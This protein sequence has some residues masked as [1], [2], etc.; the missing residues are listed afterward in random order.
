LPNLESCRFAW[1]QINNR[2]VRVFVAAKYVHRRMVALDPGLLLGL[3]VR[4][5]P[6]FEI[7]SVDCLDSFVAADGGAME[8]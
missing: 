5:A 2:S 7:G 3:G 8:R 6:M 1:S 4:A